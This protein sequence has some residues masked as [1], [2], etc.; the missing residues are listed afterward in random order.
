MITAGLVG[1]GILAFVNLAGWYLNQDPEMSR[2]LAVASER[3]YLAYMMGSWWESVLAVAW[4]APPM[5]EYIGFHNDTWFLLRRNSSTMPAF[6]SGALVF[7]LTVCS[8]RFASSRGIF[9]PVFVV[10]GITLHAIYGRSESFLFA[11]NYAWATVISL[12]VLIR[13]VA[14]HR[15][16]QFSIAISIILY[17]INLVIWRHGLDWIMDN[18]YLLPNP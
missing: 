10:F 6:L 13:A 17:V 14:P 1:V 9:I 2:F 15:L 16:F 11:A 7:M 5:D 8:I 12:G 18:N 4:I 3:Q